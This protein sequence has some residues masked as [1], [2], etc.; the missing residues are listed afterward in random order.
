MYAQITFSMKTNSKPLALPEKL[1]SLFF[2]LEKNTPTAHALLVIHR[3]ETMY[4]KA[5]GQADPERRIPATP[6]TNF[7]M[8]SVTKQF[9]AAAILLLE[10]RGLLFTGQT[11]G[12]FFPGFA[13]AVSAITLRQLLTHTS[14]IVDY[15]EVMPEHLQKQ[16]LDADV[17]ELVRS[18][19]RIY[20]SPGSDFRYSNTAFCLL[21]LI[22]EKTTGKPF[23]DFVE[24]EI[25][26]PLGMT[27]SRVYEPAETI[28]H[29]AFGYAMSD[30]QLRF[31]DQSLTSATKGDGGI[32]TS[33][34]DFEKWFRLRK[35]TLGID[36]P[37]AFE[38]C[39]A[40]IPGI[41]DARYGWGWFFVQKP[42]VPRTLFHSGSTC[43]FS[44]MVV[45]APESQTLVVFMSN[46]AGNHG[47]FKPILEVL[48]NAGVVQPG[49]H[50]WELH[51]RTN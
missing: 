18:H 50:V 40:D 8:A 12:E 5:A 4:K 32:Y 20:F 7:R 3:G 23:A 48:E 6:H 26:Q 9:T 47:A 11:L 31:S 39:A 10:Q 28:P 29:R 43:G 35:T 42:G 44:N 30:G 25:F 17:L 33:I 24:Q 21:A 19:E 46:L 37:A 36:F 1:D 2:D 15:E 16:L 41:A 38:A 45:E 14:G 22:V 49:A 51:S 34:D 27:D 13:P